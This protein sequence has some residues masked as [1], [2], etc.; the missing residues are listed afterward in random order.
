M[1]PTR[2]Q[3][4]I[5]LIVGALLLVV[6]LVWHIEDDDL[7]GAADA[8]RAY[9]EHIA[10]GDAAAANATVD[11]RR[12]EEIDSALLTDGVLDA[13]RERIEVTE[14]AVPPNEDI[15]N[16]GSVRVDVRYRLAGRAHSAVVV[17]QRD[18]GFLGLGR[19]WR[20][21][22]PLAVG[23]SVAANRSGVGPA[24]IGS[25]EIPIDITP[26]SF[27]VYPG[28]Y[29]ITAGPTRYFTGEDLTLPLAVDADLPLPDDGFLQTVVL[30]YLPNRRLQADAGKI[31][32][33]RLDACLANSPDVTD[34]ECPYPTK[35]DATGVRLIGKPVAG[36]EDFQFPDQRE[37]GDVTN[38][39]RVVARFPVSYTDGYAGV[40]QTQTRHFYGM[41]HISTDQTLRVDFDPL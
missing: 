30:E 26:S 9:V 35:S 13:A 12:F 34:D 25:V 18:N 14:V 24:R 16:D 2:R 17:A 4:P 3:R 7:D 32:L 15:L 37:S 38:P 29:P 22:T 10:N 11:P 33:D 21:T 19:Q 40:P 36:I 27:H 20:V 39:I 5:A 6:G 41:I 1:E 8:V 28:T 23:M 31:A